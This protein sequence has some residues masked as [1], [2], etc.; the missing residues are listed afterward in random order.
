MAKNAQAARSRFQLLEENAEFRY[1]QHILVLHI[2][3]P[4]IVLAIFSLLAG[5]DEA[6]TLQAGELIQ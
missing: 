6:E 4:K 5:L 1:P 3:A 2:N